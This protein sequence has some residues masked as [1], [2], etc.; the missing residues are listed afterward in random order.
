[1]VNTLDL[2]LAGT[3]I[4]FFSNYQQGAVAEWLRHWI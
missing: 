2:E 1:M 3:E 4:L